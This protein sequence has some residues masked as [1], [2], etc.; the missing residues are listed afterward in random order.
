MKKTVYLFLMLLTWFVFN[1]TV[2][3]QESRVN[4]AIQNSP[5]IIDGTTCG[6]KF[7]K[8]IKGKN[9]VSYP[10]IVNKV[11][12]GD[13]SIH[14]GDT[15]E[16]VSEM[17]SDWGFIEDTLVYTPTSRI[18]S[19]RI[20]GIKLGIKARGIYF[21]KK[22]IF[23]GQSVYGLYIN[24]NDGYFGIRT[25]MNTENDMLKSFTVIYGFS[26][27]FTD[28][29]EFSNFL[30]KKGLGEIKEDVSEYLKKKEIAYSEGINKN[31]NK[32]SISQD[33]RRANYNAA[34]SHI[35]DRKNKTF[36]Y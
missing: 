18:P 15:I 26:F 12:K 4:E 23:Q 29:N 6:M 14:T 16:L 33:E 28:F 3:A 34:I 35:L 25:A 1:N 20:N 10:I 21:L 30:Q 32:T 31:T 27:Q 22:E 9:Y 24:K 8:D 5:F 7:L 36:H 2:Q 11:L 17:P 13:K 19:S